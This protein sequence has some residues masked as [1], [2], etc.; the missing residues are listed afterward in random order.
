MIERAK[1][2][3]YSIRFKIKSRLFLLLEKYRMV[4]P[5]LRRRL[6]WVG[7][8]TCSLMVFGIGVALLND[9]QTEESHAAVAS[10]PSG[11]PVETGRA[12][13]TGISKIT[14]SGSSTAVPIWG[15]QGKPSFYSNSTVPNNFGGTISNPTWANGGGSVGYNWGWG[16]SYFGVEPNKVNFSVGSE[17]IQDVKLYG[18]C[19][20]HAGTP[21]D[22]PIS[23]TLNFYYA[24]YANSSGTFD[25]YFTGFINIG[26]A[27]KQDAVVWGRKLGIEEKKLQPV[28]T[29]EASNNT[30]M[31]EVIHDDID[32]MMAED[33]GTKANQ[34]DINNYWDTIKSGDNAGKQRQV[35]FCVNAYG[36][37]QTPQSIKWPNAQTNKNKNLLFNVSN[38]NGSLDSGVFYYGAQS[39]NNNPTNFANTGKSLLARNCTYTGHA[40]NFGECENTYSGDCNGKDF[41]VKFNGTSGPK[42]D[43]RTWEPGYYYFMI[44][45]NGGDRRYTCQAA[46]NNWDFDGQTSPDWGNL[47]DTHCYD[48]DSDESSD[49]LKVQNK[50]RPANDGE[51]VTQQDAVSSMMIFNGDEYTISQNN[52]NLGYNIK[53]RNI[54]GDNYTDWFSQ[55]ADP[56]EETVRQFQPYFKSKV[57]NVFVDDV[58]NNNFQI[59]DT[60]TSYASDSLDN[61]NNES[62]NKSNY[63]LNST[64]VKVCVKAWGPYQTAQPTDYNNGIRIDSNS[65]VPNGI[66]PKEPT[67]TICSDS[68]SG[69]NFTGIGQERKFVFNTANW[70]PGYYYFTEHMVKN[71]QTSATKPLIEDSWHSKFN[72]SNQDEATIEKFQLKPT[73]QTVTPSAK[74]N[75]ELSTIKTGI[76]GDSNH[77]GLDEG[78]GEP[79]KNQLP[80]HAGW[81][82]DAIPVLKPSDPYI[83]DSFDIRAYDTNKETDI[84]KNDNYWLKDRNGKSISFYVC[85]T[86]YG[87]YQQPQG[88]GSSQTQRI[89]SKGIGQ[90]TQPNIPANYNGDTTGRKQCFWTNSNANS[91]ATSGL[92]SKPAEDG[93]PGTYTVR[94]GNQGNDYFGPGYYYVVWNVDNNS[95]G[96]GGDNCSSTANNCD[97][98][99]DIG[100]GNT[101]NQKNG[102]FLESSWW[103]PF[104]EQTESFYSQFQPIA[105]SNISEFK[106]DNNS[107]LDK[108]GCT[109][110]YKD[111][112][113][114]CYRETGCYIDNGEQICLEE[115]PPTCSNTV[116][117]NCI[118]QSS[119][120]PSS[121]N[122]SG[123]KKST[124]NGGEGAIVMT[125]DEN[126]YN[127]LVNYVDNPEEYPHEKLHCHNVSDQISLGAVDDKAI[128]NDSYEVSDTDSRDEYWPKDKSGNFEPVKFQV[129]LYGPFAYPYSRTPS[130]TNKAGWAGSNLVTVVPKNT[131]GKAV[132]T[133]QDIYGQPI[134]QSC[135]ISTSNVGP[136]W[137]GT[138][139]PY[140]A[141]FT[142]DISSCQGGY[143]MDKTLMLTPG[144]YVSVV[145]IVRDDIPNTNPDFVKPE[146]ALATSSSNPQCATQIMTRPHNM[147]ISDRFTSAWGERRESLLVP[148]P[149]YIVTRRDNSGQDTF[150]D[151]VTINDQYW[152][153]GFAQEYVGEDGK[154]HPWTDIWGNQL[155]KYGEFNGEEGYVTTSV[156]PGDY[157]YEKQESGVGDYYT[158]DTPGDIYVNL[159]GAYPLEWGRPNENPEYC[160]ANKL[161]PRGTWRLPAEDTDQYGKD[162]PYPSPLTLYE[163]GWYVYQYTYEG[164]DRITNIKTQCGDTSEMFRIIKTDLGLVTFAGS[165]NKTAP[166]RVVDKVQVT[167]SFEE[168]D[169]DSIVK[170]SLYKRKGPVNN[171]GIGEVDG[172]PICSVIFTIDKAGTYSTEDYTDENGYILEDELGSGRCWA[173]TGGNYYW[174]EEFLFP[175]SN[176]QNPRESDYIQP[177]GKGE[178][179]ENIDIEEPPKP[180]VTTDADPTT[181]VNKPFRDM[182]LVTNIPESNT[183][184]YYLW[185][186]AYGP[187]SDG[188]VNCSNN[189]IYSNESSPITVTKNGNYYSKHITVSRPGVVYWVEHLKDKDGNIVDE[190]KCGERRE[191]TYI[192]GADTPTPS[193]FEPFSAAPLYPDS[194]YISQQLAKI[195]GLGSISMIGAWQLT[196]KNSWLLRKRH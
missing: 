156:P 171:P 68:V 170:L 124:A 18:H 147:I 108:I 30:K 168:S 19:M 26:Q 140:D 192:V 88:N 87:P 35:R 193:T 42:S 182:A 164:G 127:N 184:P 78:T 183:E 17:L 118:V 82:N 10:I 90:S 162:L 130:D 23:G 153:S 66:T 158:S 32:I 75:P 57:S 60:I 109:I 185:F 40:D 24:K 8:I 165:D 117:N 85:A 99:V 7:A 36:P 1:D 110:Y 47:N 186:T 176:P 45:I 177:I 135:V 92:V 104:G 121:D 37:Y 145:E 77:N 15:A 136:N 157:K 69:G 112:K 22:Q 11:S 14:R 98:W 3:F 97:T 143:P 73:S 128:N 16:V 189:L 155:P 83:E 137:D 134:A 41:R 154:K 169:K 159:Y 190:G 100:E 195:V 34:S 48:L 6:A 179:P 142:Q 111:G 59:T 51:C 133:A 72:P 86:V 39:D 12:A 28:A 27:S 102:D 138:P 2:F 120:D 123:R 103:S 191:N 129:K 58:S 150:I 65:K 46:L 132:E 64:N 180:I 89:P 79:K 196:N 49:P 93:G 151:Q 113:Q 144:F 84:A 194:G 20:T 146:C 5:K 126:K 106:N 29:S 122:T 76:V 115:Q 53:G 152:V 62:V 141:V 63:W 44:R 148:T 163:K 4:D 149:L 96:S 50:C 9:T 167:G 131:N 55:F 172:A 71:D 95:S 61:A 175:G 187:Y 54:S 21:R 181:S 160:V 188:T 74:E 116:T 43:S 80:S 178:S 105:Q 94:W 173:A 33:N 107:D 52:S 31:G 119:A 13:T 81:D 161:V 25:Y 101:I 166:T 174:I 114:Y 56:K 125:C 70:T 38:N 139:V 91:S 67:A